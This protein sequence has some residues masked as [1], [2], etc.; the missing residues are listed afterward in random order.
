[1]TTHEQ[2]TQVLHE[3]AEVFMHRSMGDFKRFMDESGLSPSQVSTL[4]HLHYGRQCGVSDIG[5]HLGV[6]NAA[7]SQMVERMVQQGLFTRT[8]DADD[9]RVKQIA[10]TP[11]GQALVTAGIEAR[12]RWLEELTTTLTPQEQEA[13]IAALQLLTQAARRLEEPLHK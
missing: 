8:E 5:Q 4:M 12:R 9:R 7:A 13:I 6:T 3:W 1:M 11:R 2:F 10:I